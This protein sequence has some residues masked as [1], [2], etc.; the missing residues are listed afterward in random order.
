M[1]CVVFGWMGVRVTR[2]GTL[3]AVVK[4]GFFDVVMMV[5]G[6]VVESFKQAC[7]LEYYESKN[8]F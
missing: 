2:S 4:E 5:S 6:A 8:Y 1:N 7:N 3:L